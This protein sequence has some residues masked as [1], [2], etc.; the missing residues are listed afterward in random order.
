MPRPTPQSSTP[1]VY[2]YPGTPDRPVVSLAT[3]AAPEFYEECLANGG[4]M[5]NLAAADISCGATVI[6]LFKAAA[7]AF[8]TQ[9][10][11]TGIAMSVREAV[12]R[13]HDRVM[14]LEKETAKPLKT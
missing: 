10:C 8:D 5:P 12:A 2:Y 9:A 3:M 4:R 7:T 6:A 13:T 11:S 14:D 1:L